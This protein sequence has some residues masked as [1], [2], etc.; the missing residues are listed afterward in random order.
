[1]EN[2]N[3]S[4][5]RIFVNGKESVWSEELQARYLPIIDVLEKEAEMNYFEIH[6]EELEIKFIAKRLGPEKETE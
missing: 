2:K 4:I 3:G 1:M 5:I 6:D